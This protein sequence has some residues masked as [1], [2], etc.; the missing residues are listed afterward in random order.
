[1]ARLIKK[2]SKLTHLIKNK[3]STVVSF[4][5]L[6]FY[7]RLNYQAR[8][9]KINLIFSNI[10]YQ[11]NCILINPIKLFIPTNLLFILLNHSDW[12]NIKLIKLELIIH[13]VVIVVKVMELFMLNFTVIKML[14]ELAKPLL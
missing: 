13:N 6:K 14:L 1:M 8:S 11:H 4:F 12:I 5:L 7:Y 9:I 3:L 2:L 10:F